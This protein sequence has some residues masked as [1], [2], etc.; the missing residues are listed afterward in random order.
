MEPAGGRIMLKS[1][2]KPGAE[3]FTDLQNEIRWL[4]RRIDKQKDLE[5]RPNETLVSLQVHEEELRAQNEDLIATQRELTRSQRKYRHL[6]DFAPI[7]YFLMDP[8]GVIQETNML[9]AKMIG[10]HR[11]SLSGKPLFLYIDPVYRP[12][13]SRHLRE[14][15]EGHPASAEV[16]F[17]QKNGDTLPVELFSTP[18]PDDRG[19]ITHCR[20]AATNISKR[21]QAEKSLKESERQLD[22]IVKTIP[23]I[24]YR[25]DQNGM[26][27]FI[28]E[29]I[30]R[31][32]YAP[33]DLQGKLMMS[34]V[35]PLDRLKARPRIDERR[36]GAR[37]TNGLELRLLSEDKYTRSGGG[38]GKDDS[39][40]LVNAEGL[41]AGNGNPP[42]RFIG[43]QGIAH[44]ITQRKQDEIKRM[45]L[46]A[47]LHKTSKMEAIG[48]LAGGIAH[49]FN[50]LLMGI[51][52]NISLL[53][54]DTQASKENLQHIELIE[55]CVKRGSDLTRQ[56]LGFAKNGKYN[57][58]TVDI[59]QI[60][61]DAARLFARTRKT[62][63]I[64][65]HFTPDFRNVDADRGQLDQVLINLLIN[66][67]QAMPKGGQIILATE[68]I[69]PEADQQRRLDLKPEKY[70]RILVEDTGIGMDKQIQ[71][72]IFEPFF[73]TKE[74]GRGTGM[75][76][77]SAYGIIKNHGGMIDVDSAP[78]RGSRF[79]VYLPAVTGTAIAENEADQGIVTG[80]GTILLV[81]DEDMVLNVARKMLDRLGYQVIV[82]QNG[83]QAV[84]IYQQRYKDVNMVIL[85]M[86]MPEMSGSDTYDRLKK[87]NPKIKVLLSSDYS[88]KGQAGKIVALD[89]QDYIQKPFDLAQLSKKIASILS[90]P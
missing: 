44:D 75:G 38:S 9:A 33:D 78:G 15:W 39:F 58:K 12:V 56:L 47:E 27:N 72:R 76:L 6:F 29:G 59:N 37:S 84:E 43:T 3:Q 65:Q 25:L 79:F 17:L 21:W 5:T 14:I 60:V 48:T 8:H 88:R 81:D 74:M 36:T 34:L 66:A 4:R 77:A 73:T 71:A 28:S 26:I 50:N 40:F 80:N 13:L 32:G 87:I 30:R 22:S 19:R 57:T 16:M 49:D 46:E 23:D 69:E 54:M 90:R 61:G 51:Q 53:R 41:Y 11:N 45:H 67:D 1:D 52:G 64:Y 42:G 63:K 62:I 89:Q 24:V 31:Y 2:D 82:A 7:G 86:L 70:V 20:I 55:Q 68:N 10:R 35:H 85:D 18:M 83:W